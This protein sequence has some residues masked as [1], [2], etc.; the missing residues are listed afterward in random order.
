MP[1]DLIEVRHGAGGKSAFIAGTRVRVS[2]IARLY[3]LTQEELITE[4]IQR[5]LPHLSLPQ[6]RAAIDYWRQNRRE[7]DGEIAFEQSILEK[8]PSKI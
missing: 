8:L 3:S 4:R 2:D 5:S 7:L 6:V 1:E